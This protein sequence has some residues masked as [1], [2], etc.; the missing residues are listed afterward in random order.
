MLSM[1]MLNIF[2]VFLVM[3]SPVT[4]KSCAATEVGITLTHQISAGKLELRACNVRW[5]SA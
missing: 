3:R 5:L 1:D 4:H 2:G